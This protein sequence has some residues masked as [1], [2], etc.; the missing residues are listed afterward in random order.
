MLGY[1]VVMFVT[2]AGDH[3]TDTELIGKLDSA[4]FSKGVLTLVW[5]SSNL[6]SLNYRSWAMSL[7]VLS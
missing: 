3:L 4:V 1:V 6:V 5:L 2:V 7:M